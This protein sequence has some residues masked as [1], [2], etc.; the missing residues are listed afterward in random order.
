MKILRYN[1]Y[2]TVIKYANHC[3]KPRSGHVAYIRD[4]RRTAAQTLAVHN[5][6]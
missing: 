4:C 3:L 5:A 6:D 2:K 1:R